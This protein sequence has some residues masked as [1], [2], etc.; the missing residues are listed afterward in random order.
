M[1]KNEQHSA[2]AS[3]D[4]L[5][6]QARRRADRQAQ[7]PGEGPMSN[8]IDRRH[9]RHWRAKLP[10]QPFNWP[11]L[12]GILFSLIVWIALACFLYMEIIAS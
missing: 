3:G 9:S 8:I 2:D 11:L 6:P 4:A 12:A 5:I 7:D 1:N 10:R